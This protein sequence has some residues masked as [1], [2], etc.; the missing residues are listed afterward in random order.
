MGKTLYN[1]PALTFE[2]QLIQLEER[3]LTIENK[4]KALH[5]L[6]NISYYRLSGYWYPFLEEPKSAHLFKKEAS[7]EQGF[8]LYCFDRELRKLIMGELEKIEIAV[9][10]QLI[11]QLSHK[12]GAY[13]FLEKAIFRDLEKLR[14]TVSKIRTETNRSQEDFIDNFSKKYTQKL[15]P[16]WMTLEVTS[17][18]VLSSLYSNLQKDKRGIANYFG[19]DDK[20]F[21]SW[22]H[23]LLYVRNICAHHSRLWNKKLRISPIIPKSPRK[24]FLTTS[25]NNDKVYYILSMVIY[26]L[27]TI[28][29]NH[30]F[31]MRLNDL[32]DKYPSVDLKA[33][34]FSDK[35]KE[36][37]LWKEV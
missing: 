21:S 31:R 28:N 13:W 19:L 20:T 14:K 15:P 24:T 35:W 10:T 34:G 5:L 4:D 32:F 23:T 2:E 9:R 3:G 27:N 22:L 26:L 17:F 36:E 37:E 1:K 25:A 18:G 29:P 30:S 8:K 7:F 33:L 11:Y 16:S 12:H 6:Q